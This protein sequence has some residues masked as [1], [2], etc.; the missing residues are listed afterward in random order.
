MQ[1]ITGKFYIRALN[2]KELHVRILFV[3]IACLVRIGVCAVDVDFDYVFVGTSPI[4]M[5]E[6]LYRS[7]TG[8]H[9]L[10][11]EAAPTAGGAWQAIDICHL[12]NVDMGCHQIGQNRDMKRF[13]EIYIGCKLVPMNDPYGLGQGLQSSDSGAYFSRGC[14][15]LMTNLSLLAEANGV[16]V[17]LNHKLESVYLDFDREV[18]EIL[19]N[20]KRYTVSKIVV[21]PHSAIEVENIPNISKPTYSKHPHLYLLISDPTPVRFTYMNGFCGGVSRAI[22]LTPF[23]PELEGTREQ[24]IVVQ[25]HD[26]DCVLNAS[27]FLEEFKKRGLIDSAASLITAESYVYQQPHFNLSEIQNAH[28]KASIFFEMLHTEAI[29]NISQHVARW[30]KVFKPF[31]R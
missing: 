10:I 24:L 3:L 19:T 6:A 18:A 11:L 7:Y 15:E 25:T 27:Q 20:G 4:P 12:R 28:P 17:L 23:L 31:Q 22:N 16:A 29:W 1:K 13:L 30:E 8:S 5:I 9:V 2:F 21:T 26:V 14:H